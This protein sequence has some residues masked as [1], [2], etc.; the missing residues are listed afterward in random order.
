MIRH[1]MEKIIY[2]YCRISTPTQ[3]IERQERNI[4]KS[5]P[6]AVIIKEAYTGKTM[7]RPKWNSLYKEALKKALQEKEVTIVFD[8]VSR[9][10]RNAKEG[11]ETYFELY[12]AGVNLVFLKE[13]YINT[14]TYSSTSSNSIEKTGD[15]VADIYITATNKVIKILATRQ[16]EQAFAQSEKEVSDLRQRTKEGLITA[17]INGKNLGNEKGVRLNTKKRASS[18]IYIEKK[19]RDF[20]GT[21]TDKECMTQLNISPNTYYKYKKEIK[22]KIL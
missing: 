15:E 22:E 10:S 17:K 14:E 13:P 3:N 2:G 18:I 6:S 4:K 9:M 19:C 7:E 11:I 5:Y 20:G 1:F 21:L 12:E 8:S 16:I